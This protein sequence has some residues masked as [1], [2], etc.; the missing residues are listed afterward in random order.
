MDHSHKMIEMNI[1]EDSS[2]VVNYNTKHMSIKTLRTKLSYYQDFSAICHWHEDVEFIIILKG[3]MNFFVEGKV[4]LLRE[5]TGIFVNSSR[6]HYG[7]SEKS[8]DCE[9]IGL[10]FHPKSIS[11]NQ[12][13]ESKYM[14]PLIQQVNLPMILLDPLIA[15]KEDIIQQVKQIISLFESGMDG[16][17]LV[18]Q[19]ILFSIWELLYTYSSKENILEG[20]IDLLELKK[21]ID[22]IQIQHSKKITLNQIAAA[23]TVSRSKCC[24]LFKAHLQSSPLQYVNKFRLEKSKKLLLN[25]LL[26]ISEIAHECGFSSSSYFTELFHRE[27][28]TTP[29]KFRD[30]SIMHYKM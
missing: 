18:T 20:K 17:E 23:G 6:L 5:N 26:T 28:G 12:H 2:E 24:S 8:T 1:L 11:I 16:Y 25:P 21:M 4:Y 7:F 14:S 29:K 9:F 15:W 22:F 19:S 27:I 30:K 13:I 3:E 10:L